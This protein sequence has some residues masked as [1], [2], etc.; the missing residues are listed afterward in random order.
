[1]IQV[2]SSQLPRNVKAHIDYM[3]F[4]NQG[5]LIQW[6]SGPVW[7]LWPR[8]FFKTTVK[9]TCS[10][11]EQA[12]CTHQEQKERIDWNW[13]F[14]PHDLN[15]WMRFRLMLIWI[16]FVSLL[17]RW[18]FHLWQSGKTY[19]LIALGRTYL[20]HPVQI[21]RTLKKFESSCSIPHD[22]HEF[23]CATSG[24]S[25]FWISKNSVGKAQEM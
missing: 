7:P 24:I 15:I 25:K 13:S 17:A 5:R 3:K 10:V 21:H 14:F 11:V 2:H 1:M 19:Y 16:F 6:K 12:H 20:A 8:F 9:V 22:S 4:M 23:F 18:G